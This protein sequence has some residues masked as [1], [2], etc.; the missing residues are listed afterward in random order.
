MISAMHKPLREITDHEWI[1]T[2]WF[3]VRQVEDTERMFCDSGPRTPEEAA[4]AARDI[5]TIRAAL[6]AP[7]RPL[8]ESVASLLR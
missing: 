6:A 5:E 7:P 1:T 8:G 4:R 2:V 3:E